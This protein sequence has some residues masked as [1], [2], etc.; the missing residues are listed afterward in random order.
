VTAPSSAGRTRRLPGRSVARLAH[1]YPNVSRGI[2]YIPKVVRGWSFSS[3]LTGNCL[4]RDERDSDPKAPSSS[5]L[6]GSEENKHE[7]SGCGQTN[8][9]RRRCRQVVRG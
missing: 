8:P 1:G 6:P 2:P 9:R 4:P 7:E 5:I 3:K